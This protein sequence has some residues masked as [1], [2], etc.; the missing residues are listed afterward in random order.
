MKTSN[1]QNY[2]TKCGFKK[3]QFPSSRI[4]TS[5]TLEFG[6]STAENIVISKE[7]VYS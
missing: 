6:F 2:K 4:A 7:V 5:L 1:R 3:F